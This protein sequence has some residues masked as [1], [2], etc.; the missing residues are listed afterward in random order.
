MKLLISD[1]HIGERLRETRAAVVEAIVKSFETEGQLTP[2]LVRLDGPK[3]QLVAGVHR[4]EAAKLIGWTHIEAHQI[5]LSS[6]S[7][8]LADLTCQIAEVDENVVRGGLDMAQTTLFIDARLE[9]TDRR[10]KLRKTEGEKTASI[11]ANEKRAEAL[12]A[13]RAAKTKTEK[14][15]ARERLRAADRERKAALARRVRAENSATEKTA[16]GEKTVARLANDVTEAVS[17]EL[18]LPLSVIRNARYYTKA[19]G[20]ETLR[21]M[22]GTTLA[23]KSEFLALIRLKKVSPAD[24]ETFERTLALT[25]AHLRTKKPGPPATYAFSPA[26]RLKMIT[27]EER[28]NAKAEELL[29]DAGKMTHLCEKVSAASRL[30]NDAVVVWW[31]LPVELRNKYKDIERIAA[32]LDE[33]QQLVKNGARPVVQKRTG[34][35]SRYANKPADTSTERAR[36]GAQQTGD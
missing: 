29:T 3:P 28:R 10:I 5:D 35:E 22:S 8:E 25:C 15:A 1:I 12:A 19:I 9:L 6:M 34:H 13:V 7:A 26:A 24:A 2:I 21:N 18:S 33:C 30:M 27:Q 4:I 16:N 20:R 31:K 23:R 11:Q 17:K 32:R 36:E 14:S